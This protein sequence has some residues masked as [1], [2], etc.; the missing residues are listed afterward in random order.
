MLEVRTITDDEVVAFRDAMMITFGEDREDDPGGAE[1]TRALLDL[2]RGWAAFE[3]G[4]IVGTAA[5]S[6]LVVGIPGGTLPM[7]GLTAVT[8]RPTHRRRGILRELMRVHADDARARGVA[9]S[10]LWA[11]EATIYGRFGYGVAAESDALEI[12]TRG[13]A[14]TVTGERDVCE[15]IDEAAAREQ[16]PAIYAQAI[17]GRPGALQRSPVWWRER[18]FLEAPFV[19][20]GA[21]RRRHVLVRRGG[22]AVGYVVYRQRPKFE[23]GVPAGTTD[24]IELIALDPRA[25]ASLWHFVVGIDL[26]PTATWALAPVDSVLP[27]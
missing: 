14:I 4:V 23:G 5:T 17:T 20:R 26:F 25:E 24:L 21:S 22:T 1:R 3:D 6:D 16:L 10:G 15:F 9:I 18:R 8:V 2:T 27:W 13:L 19:R 11:S 12:C 7:A